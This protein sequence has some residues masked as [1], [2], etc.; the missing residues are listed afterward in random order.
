MIRCFKVIFAC[1]VSVRSF[2]DRQ[3]AHCSSAQSIGTE[4]IVAY[5]LP[6]LHD[7]SEFL[8]NGAFIAYRS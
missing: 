2:L 6:F 7:S 5:K 1:T 4:H 3:I 8:R